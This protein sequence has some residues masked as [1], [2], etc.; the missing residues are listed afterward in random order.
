MCGGLCIGGDAVAYVPL[1]TDIIDEPCWKILDLAPEVYRFWSLCLLAA[2]KFDFVEGYLP[3]ERTLA[4]W[5][6]MSRDEAVT[7]RDRAVTGHVLDREEDGRYKVHDWDHW[8]DTKDPGAGR[9]KRKQRAKEN[10]LKAN[11]TDESRN[12]HG[13]VTACHDTS[14]NVTAQLASNIYQN[15]SPS[16]PQGGDDDEVV[17]FGRITFGDR[18]DLESLGSQLPGWRAAKYPDSWIQDAF[19]VAKAN[20]EVNRTASYVTTCL[21][22]WTK[23]GGPDPDEVARAKPPVAPVFVKAEPGWNQPRKQAP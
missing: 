22:R 1:W 4:A 13:S 14:R 15:S 16:I 11:V 20:S 8:R 18:F 21:R 7:L 6:H 12:G 9:R 17:K 19:L 23:K 10:A 2:Q 5:I 3:D